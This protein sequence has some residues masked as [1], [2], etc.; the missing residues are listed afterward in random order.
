MEGFCTR[1]KKAHNGRP[2]TPPH[3]NGL[4]PLCQFSHA[5]YL[6]GLVCGFPQCTHSTG[7]DDMEFK[8]DAPLD[9]DVRERVLFEAWPCLG[10][11]ARGVL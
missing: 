6:T 11:F 1:D 2:H 7:L 9:M 3:T 8:G 10:M 4:A 5:S